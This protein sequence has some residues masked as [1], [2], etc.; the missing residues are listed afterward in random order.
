[1][2]ER[3]WY[4]GYKGETNKGIFVVL[5]EKSDGFVVQYLSGP[6]EGKFILIPKAIGKEFHDL[7]TLK[8]TKKQQDKFLDIFY[9]LFPRD[10]KDAWHE[11]ITSSKM[12]KVLKDKHPNLFSP[13]L[14]KL[15]REKEE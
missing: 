7:E 2:T 13:V 12:I 1:M 10:Y 3:E 15:Y 9:D 5:K 11:N 8:L 4:S 14:G 6:W